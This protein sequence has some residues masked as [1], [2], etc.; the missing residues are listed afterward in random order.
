MRPG[1]GLV[2]LFVFAAR[3][4]ELS[5]PTITAWEEYVRSAAA[6]MQQRFRPGNSFL[7]VDEKPDWELQVRG[8][9]I[10]VLPGYL[11]GLTSVRDGLIHDWLGAAFVPHT[12]LDRVLAVVTDYDSYKKFY[13]PVV[14]DSETL[15]RRG[16]EYRF[17]MI[18]SNK[19]GPIAITFYTESQCSFFE[20]S[21][22][23]WY[24]VC[25]ST[26]IRE[27]ENYGSANQRIL[28]E[29]QGKGLLWRLSSIS[30]FE[31]RNGGVYIE[32]EAIALSR[33]I[34]ASLRWL[35]EPMVRKVSRKSLISSLSQT[36]AAVRTAKPDMNASLRYTGRRVESTGAVQQLRR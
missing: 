6:R 16:S 5:Q 17:S 23:R 19:S 24:S 2:L 11:Q 13:R 36:E 14:L 8:G 15:S 35:V 29:G 18:L 20:V 30:R 4:A 31:E 3:A 26:R 33:N 7:K 1:A 10:L 12:T 25:N 9:G 22:R 34:P 21:Q 32:L 28:N 27:I